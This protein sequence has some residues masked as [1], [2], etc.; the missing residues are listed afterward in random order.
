MLL[1]LRR[2]LPPDPDVKGHATGVRGSATFLPMIPSDDLIALAHGLADRAG[3]VVLPF[4]RAGL[5]AAG[6]ADGSPVTQADR[7]AEEAMRALLAEAVPAHGIR[8]EE[9]GA[10]REDAEL[11]WALDPIDGT[12]AFL[13]GKP[14]FTTLIALLH[15]GRPVLG[16]IDQPFTGER[17]AGAAGRPTLFRDRS[18][19]AFCPVR[20][21]ACASLAAARLSSTDPQ[22]FSDGERRAFE[23]VAGRVALVSWGGDGYQ[24]GLVASG[25]LDLVIEA[26]LALHDWAALVPVI[27]GAGGV[28]TDWEGRPPGTGSR[29]DVVAAGDAR[30]H[31]EALAALR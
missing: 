23:Q 16:V 30:C 6:K 14:L 25:S 12:R 22:Y 10:S 24:Y 7:G 21:R 2:R 18:T 29:G 4:F 8:G 19:G 27:A 5:E 28:I 9:L 1:P 15:R 13:A 17:W 26:G 20:P 3:E 11:V 31:A